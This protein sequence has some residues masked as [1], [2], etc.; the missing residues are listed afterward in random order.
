MARRNKQP[1]PVIMDAFLLPAQVSGCLA[2]GKSFFD[3]FSYI[4]SLAKTD[5]GIDTIDLI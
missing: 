1:G 4:I 3:Y 2:A 5:N